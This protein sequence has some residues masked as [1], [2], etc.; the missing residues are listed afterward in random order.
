MLYGAIPVYI[1]ASNI[2]KYIPEECYIDAERFRCTGELFE[3]LRSLRDED[4]S[5]IHASIDSFLTSPSYAEFA[6]ESY[7]TTILRHLR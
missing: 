5:R 7:V 1:G 3:Y 6:V 4:I 2:A